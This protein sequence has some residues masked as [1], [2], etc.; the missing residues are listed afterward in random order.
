MFWKIAGFEFRYQL[1]QPV[2]WV[3]AFFF[4]LLSFGLMCSPNV[5]LTGAASAIH[6]NAPWAIG[7]ASVAFTVWYMLVTTAFVANVV[8]RDDQTGFGPIA[9]S[10]PVS[11]FDYLMGR[12]TGAFGAAAVGYLAV[13]IG[14][15]IG[16]MMPWVDKETLGPNDIGV[17]LYA[18]FAL[19][20][21]SVLLTSALF[22]TVATV[23]RSMMWTYVGVIA[24]F[25]LNTILGVTLA[26]KPELDKLAA[27]IE[28]FGGG[29]YSYM[30]KYWTVAERNAAIPPFEGVLLFNRLIMVGL[31]LALLLLGYSLYRSGTRGAKLQKAQKL[32]QLAAKAQQ[33][34]ARGG[35]LPK[36]VFDGALRSTQFW[37]RT[38]FE[39]AQVFK[40][41]AYA[42][43]LLIG[44]LLSFVQLYFSGDLYGAHPYPTTRN[45]TESL[46]Y[47][48]LFIMAYVISAYYAGELVWRERERNVHEIVGASAL[49]DW[50]FIVP[51]MLALALVMVSVVVIAMVAG[52]LLQS[53]RGFTDYEIARYF[54]WYVIPTSID[55]VL[56]AVLAVFL[57]VISP[58]KF[59][60]WGLMVVF[61]LADIIASSLGFGD[62]LY[63]Y[64]GGPETPL[65]EMNGMGHFWIGS[66]WFRAYW[67]AFAVILATLS[68]T[69]WRRGAETRLMPQFRALPHRLRGAPG[70]LAGFALVAFVAIGGWIFTNTHVWNTYRSDKEQEDRQALYERLIYDKF[71]GKAYPEGIPHPSIVATKFD[72]DLYPHEPRMVVHGSYVLENRTG[73]PL[74]DIHV[75]MNPDPVVQ[76]WVIDLPGATKT[77]LPAAYED[78]D[79][80][81]YHLATP[82]QP[83]QRLTMGFTTVLG[84]RGFGNDVL[85]TRLVDNGTFITNFDFAPILPVE[86]GGLLENPVKRR[87]H[88]LPSEIRPPKL[89]DDSAAI[90]AHNYLEDADFQT[91]DITVHTDADQTPLAPGEK[92]SDVTANGRRTARFVNDKPVLGFFAVLSA[93]YAEKKVPYKGVDL[94]VY[95]DPHNPYNV[96]RMITALKVALDYYQPNFHP[97]QF[98]QA[99]IAEFPALVRGQSYAQSFPNIFPWEE[100]LGFTADVRNPDKID[101][102][103][104]VA[105]HEFGHQWWAYQVIGADMQGDTLLSETM[106]QYSALMTME[107]LYGPTKIRQFLKYELDAYLRGRGSEELEELPL[108]Q[109]ESNQGYIHYRKGAVAMYLLRDQIGEQKVD[110]ALKKLIDKYGFRGAPYP[111]SIDLIALLKAEAPDREQLIDDLFKYITIWDIKTS[112]MK[113]K[114]RTD[115]KYDVT[116]TIEAKKFRADGKGKET[117]Q[118]MKA[119]PFDLGLFA[120]KPGEHGF[121]PKDVIVFKTVSLSTGT[122][123][124]SFV[125]DRAPTWGGADPYNKYIDRD[126]NDNLIAASN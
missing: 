33:E 25:V 115:G 96:D 6:K 32:Q 93:R 119:E 106:A 81:I 118:A 75:H 46:M 60:G 101:Y 26:R 50:A 71:H 122:Q 103:T 120:Q 15:F 117:D 92:V 74:N 121:G 59:V 21:P 99:R 47:G 111:A 66:Y 27:T 28:P 40:S 102:V 63:R 10:T 34:V 39:M 94:V 45:I 82:M 3:G 36:P 22:F 4:A 62:H 90:R 58:H 51:K 116:V 55:Y 72:V 86:R 23:T 107:K 12:F 89:A 108:M 112:E 87:A 113:V 68:Y 1:R 80:R 67:M 65:S 91:S 41:P 85:N 53:V 31:A 37:K 5:S 7:L 109:V 70:L 43:L 52:L 9:R 126:S 100:T 29:A 69:L 84:T 76:S 104:Y 98:S 18:Y 64:G 13:P 125:V 79:Y 105:A 38:R 19:A 54:T 44:L 57:A 48:P 83:G 114:K 77:K 8:I 17:Y 2:F 97:F 124:F 61:L 42:I 49:P 30:S 56:V 16:S 78:L 110:D 95:Y 14:M 11:K 24:F 20:L 35:P 73:Q 123:R 88:G